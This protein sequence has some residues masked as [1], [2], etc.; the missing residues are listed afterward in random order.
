LVGACVFFMCKKRRKQK[1]QEEHS[2]ETT[3]VDWDTVKH[4]Y[5][6]PPQSKFANLSPLPAL[7]TKPTTVRNNEEFASNPTQK[8]AV[9]PPTNVP[10]N[11][12]ISTTTINIPEV[13]NGYHR[14][15][16]YQPQLLMKSDDDDY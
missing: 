6:E 13:S 12:P 5:E 16:V 9:S 4:K 3:E 11:V 14:P 1:Q 7:N 8:A 10:V 15:N 2:N